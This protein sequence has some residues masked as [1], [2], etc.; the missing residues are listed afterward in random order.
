[1]SGCASGGEDI[2]AFFDDSENAGS[3]YGFPLRGE[4]N[5]D[6][7]LDLDGLNGKEDVGNQAS[8]DTD[9][10]EEEARWT[11]QLDDIQVPEF[12]E[13]TGLNFVIDTPNE[14]NFFLAFIGDDLGI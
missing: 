3:F 10:E 4:D 9:A 2:P 7:D 5:N 8:D 12:V 1:M 11:D 13:A 6:S 14:V